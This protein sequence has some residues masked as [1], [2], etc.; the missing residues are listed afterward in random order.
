MAKNLPKDSN[1]STPESVQSTFLVVANLGIGAA[2]S[3][4]LGFLP[5]F[6]YIPIEGDAFGC[7]YPYTQRLLSL[8]FVDALKLAD[9]AGRY[10]GY[11]ILLA[12][13]TK[14]F[15]TEF[16]DTLVVFRYF[17]IYTSF[18][19]VY[20]LF[21]QLRA[22]RF[23]SFISAALFIFFP[24]V[25]KNILMNTQD[26]LKVALLA[27]S[28]VFCLKFFEKPKWWYWLFAVV[29]AFYLGLLR[30]VEVLPF[31]A[32]V[33][34]F[35]F[36]STLPSKWKKA[37]AVTSAPMFLLFCVILWSYSIVGH[38]GFSST[39]NGVQIWASQ[40]FKSGDWQEF[41]RLCFVVFLNKTGYFIHDYFSLESVI[42]MRDTERFVTN[43]SPM[44]QGVWMY[45][46]YFFGFVSIALLVFVASFIQWFSMERRAIAFAGLI[47]AGFYIFGLQHFEPRY[48][49]II[50][51]CI[52]V[53]IFLDPRIYKSQIFRI[54]TVCALLVCLVQSGRTVEA[55][56]DFHVKTLSEAYRWSV[57]VGHVCDQ[58]VKKILIPY[59][60]YVWSSFRYWAG[61][62]CPIATVTSNPDPKA[63]TQKI[64]DVFVFGDDYFVGGVKVVGLSY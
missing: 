3:L 32:F 45:L 25:W 34:Y 64:G 15:R 26:S 43:L 10:P 59:N 11:P 53:T 48:W 4:L 49:L 7:W 52:F 5:L 17:A 16:L 39:S 36:F 21:V 58:S 57:D 44:G 20:F 40:A 9:A 51:F 22:P 29:C 1:K 31:L 55:A 30:V 24:A 6:P 37:F 42:S 41:I 19:A 46:Y 12:L 13:F 23:F 63:V 47:S 62:A 27:L 54:V 28:I 35:T 14:V 2:I 33:I 18:F 61:A 56:K 60:F 8:N 50:A 38:S